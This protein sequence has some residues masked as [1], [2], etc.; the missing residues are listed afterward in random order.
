M[1]DKYVGLFRQN[2]TKTYEFLN[3][4]KY[5]GKFCL[6]IWPFDVFFSPDNSER[7][8]TMDTMCIR[9]VD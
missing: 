1:F 5:F 3:Q 8:D 9:D 6:K 4:N 7:R 2:F